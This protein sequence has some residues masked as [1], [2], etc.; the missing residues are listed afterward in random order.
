[1]AGAQALAQMNQSFVAALQ[2]AAL[3]PCISAGKQGPSLSRLI[4]EEVFR[5]YR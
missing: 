2:T 4:C 5:G 3:G 1:M